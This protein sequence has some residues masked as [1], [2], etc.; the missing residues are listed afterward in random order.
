MGSFVPVWFEGQTHGSAAYDTM[1]HPHDWVSAWDFS[2]WR[3]TRIRDRLLSVV[4][5]EGEVEAAGR[6]VWE[7]GGEQKGIFCVMW[8]VS[9]EL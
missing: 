7:G 8:K 4:D 2:R 9:E 6:S 5:W 3:V 1:T